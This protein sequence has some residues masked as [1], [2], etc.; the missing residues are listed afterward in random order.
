MEETQEPVQDRDTVRLA[1]GRK[2]GHDWRIIFIPLGEKLLDE[3]ILFP[4]FS[5]LVGLVIFEEGDGFITNTPLLFLCL[6]KLLKFFKLLNCICKATNVNKGFAGDT[7]EEVFQ[8]AKD[9]CSTSPADPSR[10]TW[11]SFTDFPKDC[12]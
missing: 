4:K 6:K 10:T 7:E 5:L 12:A 1:G 9:P 2:T 8:F 3:L 11:N